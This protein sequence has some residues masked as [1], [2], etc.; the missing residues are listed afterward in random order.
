VTLLYP[1]QLQF[2]HVKGHQDQKKN[3]QLSIQERLNID[4]NKHAASLPLPPRDLELG[5]HPAPTAGYPH[6]RLNTL[7]VTQKMQHTLWDAATQTAYF[8]YLTEKFQG[9][10]SPATDIHWQTLRYTLKKF[11][12]AE[13]HTLS[14]F[15]HE[16]LPLLD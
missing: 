3:Q 7:I 1:Y 11:K 14:K 12:S 10:T 2:H 8:D 4:C 16:W 15:I 9:I 13:R 5:W 6:L